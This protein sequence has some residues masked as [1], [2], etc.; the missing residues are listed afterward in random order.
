MKVLTAAQMRRMDRYAIE[1]LGIIGPVLMENAGLEIVRAILE[2]FPAVHQEKVV[3]VAGKGNNGGDGFVVA[4][5][6]F[7]RGAKPLILLLAKKKAVQGDAALNL[8][9]AERMGI[10]IQEAGTPELW[11]KARRRLK[12]ATLVVDAVFG[13][14]LTQP[15]EGLFA[16]V[17]SDINRSPALPGGRGYSFRS[18]FGHVRTDW[19]KCRSRSDSDHGRSQDRARVRA[20]R[21]SVRR[22]GCGGYQHAAFYVSESRPQARTSGRDFHRSLF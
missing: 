7:N 20:H 12:S 2:R 11:A 19:P 16:K 4:R 5:H 3:I 1:K 15:A 17:I 22:M 10:P 8:A 21:G 18:F 6:L 14:G 9:I 13:T